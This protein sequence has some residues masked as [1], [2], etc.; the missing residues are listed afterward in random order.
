VHSMFATV[1]ELLA[2]SAH[3][4]GLQGFATKR[5]LARRESRRLQ[6]GDV[7]ERIFPATVALI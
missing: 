6:L 5:P 4:N 2:L 3:A 7:D 1:A